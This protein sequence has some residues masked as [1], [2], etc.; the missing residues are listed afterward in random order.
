MSATNF[1][2][3]QLYR[4]STAAAAPTA[5]NLAAGELAINLTDE[6]LFFK[7][8]AGTVKVL[9]SSGASTV[10]GSNTQVQ[11]NNNGVLGGSS[12]FVFDGTNV[13]ISAAS[14]ASKLDIGSGDLRFSST[15]QRIIGNMSSG[16]LA[17]RLAFQ[18][19]TLNTSTGVHAIPNGTSLVSGFR[20]E[21][22]SAFT[23]GQFASMDVNGGTD[24][25]ITSGIRGSGTY[26]PLTFYTNGSERM[27]ITSA[28]DVG[29]GTSSP[30]IPL[31]ITKN[32]TASGALGYSNVAKL[33]D[34]SGNKGLLIGYTDASQTTVLT[35]NSSA[36][37]SN[38]AFWT[39]EAAGSGWSER[40]RIT[41][42]GSVGIGTDVPTSRLEV[43]GSIRTTQST[44][45]VFNMQY[46][47]ANAASRSWQINHDVQ[48]YGDFAIQQSTTQTG[49]TYADRLY[50]DAGGNVGIGSSAIPYVVGG[51][52]VFNVN[53]TSS[54]I[55][56]LQTAGSNRGYLYADGSLL[57]LETET[58]VAL[59]LTT[60]AAQPISFTT[61]GTEKMRITD[62]GDVGIGISTP[63]AKLH[64]ATPA[65]GAGV[66]FRY[67]SGTNNPGLFISTIEATSVCEINATGSTGNNNL[68]IATS[69]TER[70]RINSSGEVGI[71]T[72]IGGG[73]LNVASPSDARAITILNRTS[74]NGYGGIYFRSSDGSGTQTSILNERSGTD[75]GSLLF[76]SKPTGGSIAEIL[77]LDTTGNVGI[78]TT[79][80]TNRLDVQTPSGTNVAINATKAGTDAVNI[81]V[82]TGPFINGG[83]F[84]SLR[85]GSTERARIDSSGN[86]LVGTTDAG[87]TTGVGLKL[88]NSAV[89]PTYRVVMDT[90]TSSQAPIVIYNTNATNNGY[91]FYVRSDG[92][93]ANFQAND[94]NLSDERLKKDIELAGNYLDKI[95]A[96][97]VK[98]FLF[99]DQA[100]Q[101]KTLG[102]LAQD[103]DAVAPELVDHD[104]FGKTP[105]GEAPYLS[106]YQTD[107]QYALMKCIQE[108]KVKND[109]LAARVAQLEGN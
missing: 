78:G 33:V 90:A 72:T 24:V 16:T 94:I 71:G 20:A 61:N 92:G 43:A 60:N 28:G 70:M 26:V 103:V 12:N 49:N 44:G 15:G 63:G 1:T 95:C 68:A 55:M 62:A 13:G 2:P 53:G 66:I 3:I 54:T 27:R 76:Y 73:R 40:M 83:A 17:N 30:T 48:V 67:A 86:L 77:R 88:F 35:A 74:D 37:S 81:G 21:S 6:K 31:E 32:G 50:I 96:I 97:P 79:A 10:G 23:N 64:V 84:L 14:P 9:A 51:R 105:D 29:I 57:S 38:M 22:D 104:G 91:R 34:A 56:S 41:A 59:R 46:T 25:R 11:Y 106:I 52:T 80:P 75:G 82:D 65:S 69:G 109:E 5:G 4:T 47:T 102:V 36:A 39:Y 19:S 18:S 45:G 58:G 98:S 99:K 85:V 89:I 87:E 100:D 93:I 8:A 108:L 42:G 107:L 7:N 101:E